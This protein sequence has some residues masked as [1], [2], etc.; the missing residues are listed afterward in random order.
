MP[1]VITHFQQIDYSPEMMQKKKK[2]DQNY[3]IGKRF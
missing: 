2:G 1:S 3:V